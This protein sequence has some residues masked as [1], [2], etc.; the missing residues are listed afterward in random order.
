MNAYSLGVVE[1]ERYPGRR[2]T[3]STLL[4]VVVG[5]LEFL[6]GEGRGGA[7]IA[8]VMDTEVRADGAKVGTVG[9]LP[10][11]NGGLMAEV[12]ASIGMG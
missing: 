4:D 8:H 11:V 7:V 5:L 12:A 3:Y 2:M 6:H 1:P 9:I 10:R